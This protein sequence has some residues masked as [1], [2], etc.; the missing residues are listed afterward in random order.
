[1]VGAV[2][3]TP[4]TLPTNWTFIASGLTQTILGTGIESG[5]QYIDIRYNGTATSSLI[6]IIL[7][8]SGVISGTVGQTFSWSN[9]LKFIASPSAPNSTRLRITERNSGGG[10]LTHGD[11]TITPTTTLQR[12]AYTRVNTEAT[13]AFVNPEVIF[14]LIVGATYD[15]TIRIAAPQMELGAYATTFIPTTT[16]A[17]TRLVDI[18]GKTGIGSLIGSPAGTLFFQTQI[19]T[20]GL[21]RAF[22]VVQ[23]SSYAT[24]AIRI[25]CNPSNQW[26]VQVRVATTSVYDQTFTSVGQAFTTGNFKVAFAYNTGTNGCAFYVNGVQFLQSTVAT[27]PSLCTSVFLGT[28]LISGSYDLNVSDSFDQAALFPTRLTNARLAEITTL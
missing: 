24:N 9:Y 21:T 6:R 1:M 8:P 4:G 22:M 7:E 3:G 28:R 26:R 11:F 17:V 2:A 13:C 19:L 20:T 14:V 5:I 18:A 15:F 27:T 10:N 12:F 16:A 25:E 23:D